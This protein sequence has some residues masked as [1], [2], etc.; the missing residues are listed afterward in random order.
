VKTLTPFFFTLTPKCKLT[1]W[2]YIWPPSPSH[3]S[4]P[5]SSHSLSVDRRSN[6]LPWT[7]GPSAINPH[8]QTHTQTH[9]HLPPL[10]NK[11]PDPPTLILRSGFL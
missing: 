8:T 3:W 9:T 10:I 5:S 6:F 2:A 4:S 7:A 1:E 11:I